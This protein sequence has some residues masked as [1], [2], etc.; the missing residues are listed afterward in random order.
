MAA[1]KS[2]SKRARST[3]IEGATLLS[4]GEVK[5]IRA[6]HPG[7]MTMMR[8]LDA[9]LQREH[10][11]SHA[12]FVALMFL[13]EASDRTLGLSE[14]ARRCQQS[15]SAISRTV[16]RLEAQGL[17]RREQSS[18]D[19]RA[20]NAVLTDAGLTRLEQAVP[21]HVVSLRRHLF[22][23]LNSVDLKTI[24][25]AFERIAAAASGDPHAVP[26]QP[27]PDTPVGRHITA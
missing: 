18:Q 11:M 12:E 7:F 26:G 25:D 5:V 23:H 2:G 10:R 4:P 8:Q 9:D 1:G 21:T 16:G 15:L 14:L 19:A 20:Y 24:G 6:L 27:S 17:V 22:D 13:S 3:K